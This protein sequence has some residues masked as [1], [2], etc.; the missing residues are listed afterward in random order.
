MG[1]Q[2]SRADSKDFIQVKRMKYLAKI[3]QDKDN[4]IYLQKFI[5]VGLSMNLKAAKPVI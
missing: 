3:I 1:W 5:L 2:D 4:L